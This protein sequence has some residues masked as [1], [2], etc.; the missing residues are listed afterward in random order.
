MI[1]QLESPK[2]QR[3]EDSMV[4]PREWYKGPVRDEKRRFTDCCCLIVFLIYLGCM[5]AVGVSAFKN[6][7]HEDIT[8]LY[9]SSGNVC[10]KGDAK[11]FKYLFMQTFQSPYKSTCVKK[12]P[13]F[14]Y[15]EIKYGSPLPEDQKSLYFKD[16][17]DKHSGSSHTSN[18]NFTEKEAFGYD[19]GF[20][21]GYYTKQ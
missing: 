21:N 18:K 15:N 17:R 19:E 13:K 9:D 2:S 1:S 3:I 20:A 6:S 10:G 8:K 7:S 12:C 14:D 11:D 16:F 4:V 5:V